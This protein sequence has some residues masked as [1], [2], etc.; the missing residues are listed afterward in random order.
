[1]VL[2]IEEEAKRFIK[3]KKQQ[4]ISGL[5]EA[6][7]DLSHFIQDNLHSSDERDYAMKALKEMV[8]WSRS[9]CDKHS[10]K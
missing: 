4:F 7:E 2:N 6:A 3:G 9:C 8:L 10:I 5:E 1:M